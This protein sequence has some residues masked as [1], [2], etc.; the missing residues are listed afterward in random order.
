L[1]RAGVGAIDLVDP[2]RVAPSNL[3]RQL[4][5]LTSTVGRYKTDAAAERFLD[6]NPALKLSAFQVL[7]LPETANR[8]DFGE[9]DYVVDAIDNVSGKIELALRAREAKT[10]IISAMGAGNKLDPTRFEVADLYA[11]SVCPLAR[12]MRYELKKRG[13]ERLKVVYSKE[14]PIVPPSGGER[15]PASISFV[16]PAM[17]LILA[18]EVIRDL[19]GVER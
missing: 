10:P 3:N 6:I 5:A 16:P 11:T 19:A 8:F 12:V 14:K 9:Y 7:F 1:V 13:I 15:V 18:G 2:D 17:G 4:I